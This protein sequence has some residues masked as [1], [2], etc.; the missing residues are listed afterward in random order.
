MADPE[1]EP[2]SP[3]TES[4]VP[5]GSLHGKRSEATL[6]SSWAEL[7]QGPRGGG[8]G[9]GGCFL[10]GLWPPAVLEPVQTQGGD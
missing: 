8:Q 7:R 2:R 6:L 1:W 9:V 4:R 10:P 5:F 3:D